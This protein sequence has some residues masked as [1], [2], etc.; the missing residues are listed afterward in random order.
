M[1]GILE[2]KVYVWDYTPTFNHS[3]LLPKLPLIQYGV[4]LSKHYF[5]TF[6][7]L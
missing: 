3:S 6:Q 7:S 5:K 4:I 2:R 1:I